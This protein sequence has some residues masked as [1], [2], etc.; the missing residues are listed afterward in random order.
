MVWKGTLPANILKIPLP[1]QMIT[2]FWRHEI[3][4]ASVHFT[5][6]SIKF[7]DGLRMI[8]HKTAKPCIN[9]TWIALLIHGSGWNMAVNSVW[10]SCFAII[11]IISSHLA[12]YPE[13]PPSLNLG[14]RL[15]TTDDVATL[16]FHLSLSSA[17]LR[18][19]P[20][21]IPVHS[22]MLSSSLLLDPFTVLCR[23]VFAM[24][25]DLEM[26]P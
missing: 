3:T 1:G 15:G 16:P 21:A 11:N 2:S 7:C 19:S 6:D 22:L 5:D 18:E 4:L 9:S 8:I 25:E 23:I 20:D 17:A 10:F 26:W 12:S 24:L 14:S 13:R